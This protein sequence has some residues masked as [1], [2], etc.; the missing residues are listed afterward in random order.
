AEVR[1]REG[2]AEVRRREGT[3]EVRR[4]EGT[5]EVRRR[6]GTAEVRERDGAAE[7]RGRDGAA[8]WEVAR[9]RT[10]RDRDRERW[11]AGGLWGLLGLATAAF[12]TALRDLPWLDGPSGNVLTGRRMLAALPLTALVAGG[13]LLV[14][15]VGAVTLRSARGALLPGAAL[16]SVLLAL[17]AVPSAFGREPSPVGGETCARAARFLAEGMGIDGPEPLLRWAPTAAQ[18]LCLVPL[19]LLLVGLDRAYRWAPWPGRWGVLYLVAVG[20]WVWR[21][22]LAPMALPLCGVLVLAAA[23]LPLVAR[24]RGN[25]RWAP[26]RVSGTGRAGGSNRSCPPPGSRRGPGPR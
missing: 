1:R 20:G 15:F 19:W 13:L 7:V 8:A 25:G 12:W 14:V 24:G 23:S 16:G 26:G 2:T 3:A 18:L 21:Q 10:A 17:Y 4:R 9:G 22:E 5:A 11:L 6:E